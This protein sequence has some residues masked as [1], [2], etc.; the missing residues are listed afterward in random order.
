MRLCRKFLLTAALGLLLI[1][2]AFAQQRKHLHQAQVWVGYVSSIRV[3]E[4]L[5]VWNDFHAVPGAF[6]IGRHGLSVHTHEHITFT[7]GYAWLFHAT[8]KNEIFR[9]SEHRPWG[10]LVF[11]FPM[12]TKYQFH[13][14]IRYDMRFRQHVIGDEL[15]NDFSLVHRLRFMFSVR[16]PLIG[17]SLGAKIPFL[18]LA[19]ETLIHLGKQVSSNNLDQNRTWLMVGYERD[20]ITFQLGYMYRFAPSSTMMGEYRH[21]HGITLWVSQVFRTKKKHKEHIEEMLHREP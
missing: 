7:T 9:R 16:R 10:Q 11:N 13:Q 14:R 5:S 20:N 12:G 2:A 6:F 4:K 18:V 1:Q 19:N 21:L 3:H 15:M 17:K 8:P